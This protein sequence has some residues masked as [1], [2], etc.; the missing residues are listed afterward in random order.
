[1]KAKRFLIVFAIS[2]V[3]FSALFF[4]FL[5]LMGTP[6]SGSKNAVF[7][8]QTDSSSCWSGFFGD[9]SRQ[10][11]GSG[12][13]AVTSTISIFAGSVQ[14]QSADGMPLTLQLIIDG[15]LVNESTTTADYGIATASGSG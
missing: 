12:E 4:V 6:F 8:V 13:Y 11:C 7:R 15:E 1:V 2:I 10:G 3:F 5:S 14:K 9:A